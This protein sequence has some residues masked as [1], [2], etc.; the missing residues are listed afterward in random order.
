MFLW[1]ESEWNDND[2]PKVQASWME[3][4]KK[5]KDLVDCWTA[6]KRRL[7]QGVNNFVYEA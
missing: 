3:I 7:F 2:F 1:T 4:S 5:F 6:W